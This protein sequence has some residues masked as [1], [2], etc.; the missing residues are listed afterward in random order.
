MPLVRVAMP[1]TRF[2][3]R[4]VVRSLCCFAR[5]GECWSGRPPTSRAAPLLCVC[6]PSGAVVYV[7]LIVVS[8]CELNKPARNLD[9]NPRIESWARRCAS[10]SKTGDGMVCLDWCHSKNGMPSALEW[11]EWGRMG[12]ASATQTSADWTRRQRLPWQPP[13]PQALLGLGKSGTSGP[14]PP[15]I[16]CRPCLPD[17]VS[18]RLERSRG[19]GV[20]PPH[21]RCM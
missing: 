16:A 18:V 14:A 19:V 2:V 10:L 15:A 3:V 1:P 7:L 6:A 21:H 9:A 8:D 4:R 20:I 11:S 5:R 13:A 17:D 12:A